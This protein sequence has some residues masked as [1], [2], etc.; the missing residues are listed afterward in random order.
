MCI[1]L[2]SSSALK[3]ESFVERVA[4]EP[5]L[6]MKNEILLRKCCFFEAESVLSSSSL[7]YHGFVYDQSGLFNLRIKK[8][9]LPSVVD[10][11]LV[12]TTV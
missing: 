2:Q 4:N 5:T 1:L 3:F 11:K 8:L 12:S 9:R 7:V 6:L 10:I